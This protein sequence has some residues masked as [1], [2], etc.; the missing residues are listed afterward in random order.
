MK[1][2]TQLGLFV[3]A[4]TTVQPVW[5]ADQ[6]VTLEDGRQ[7]ILHDDFT[8]QYHQQSTKTLTSEHSHSKTSVTS[9][10]V[11][12]KANS[13]TQNAIPLVTAS[14][15]VNVSL[16]K[17]KNI[18]QLS[19][20]GVDILLQAPQYK[21]GQLIIPTM[22]TNQGSKSVMSIALRV[23]LNNAD[24]QKIES[25]DVTLWR[26][27]KRMPETYFRAKT[28]QKGK[29]IIFTVPKMNDYKIQTEIIDV[30]LW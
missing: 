15:A 5:A 29:D 18:Q 24:N 21:D 11:P 4:L 22:L 14:K 2:T 10:A 27:I 30:E 13:E 3:V 25:Q 17:P 28:Q 16:S 1:T 23:T 7:V 6:T 8:W 19:N 26:S 20:S 12:L 9:Q